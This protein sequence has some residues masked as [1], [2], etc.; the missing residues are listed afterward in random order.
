MNQ[1][2]LTQVVDEALERFRGRDLI[3]SAEVVDVLLD[4]R[5]LLLE[6]ESLEQL[7]DE[8]DAPRAVRRRSRARP[9]P[10]SSAAAWRSPKLAP[11]LPRVADDGA[12]VSAGVAAGRARGRR[13]R[14]RHPAS[15]AATTPPAEVAAP[16]T[17]AALATGPSRAG[18]VLGAAPLARGRHQG[19]RHPGLRRRPTRARA[20][21]RR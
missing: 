19:R 4:L 2:E 14:R 20:E 6:V 17:T 9:S 11:V 18:D 5:L 10:V 8:P 21:R 1:Q 7:L 12:V 13:G 16:T 15:P 3:A